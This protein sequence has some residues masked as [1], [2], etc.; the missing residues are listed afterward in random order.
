MAPPDPEALRA[1]VQ[2]CLL[3]FSPGGMT[4]ERT[5]R[6][7][8]KDGFVV[9]D[10]TLEGQPPISAL[11]VRPDAHGP[12]PAVLY[13]HAQNEDPGLGRRELTRG[14]GHLQG[15]YGP[16]L[17]AMGFASLA[18]DMTGFADRRRE[19]SLQ[20]TATSLSWWGQ[21]LF[22]MM[23]DDLSDALGYLAARPDVDDRRV[24]TLGL[25]LGGALAFWLAAMDRRVA[26]TAHLCILGDALP[27]I[28]AG[29]HERL[30]PAYVV[31]GL[32]R[33]AEIGQVAGLV[34]PRPQLVCLGGT[35]PLTPEAA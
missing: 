3:G 24:F 2:G 6:E 32:L 34:A 27:L 13:A 35:D 10:L 7:T 20:A 14:S 16:V 31:P 15:A 12:F 1:A 19:G 33:I 23:L 5:R 18:I 28:G 17:A 9:E 30:A 26:G 22:A 21:S 25:S 8:R 29:Q 11:L 4:Y